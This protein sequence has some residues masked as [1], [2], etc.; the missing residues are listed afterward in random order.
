[1]NK[2]A[3]CM[4]QKNYDQNLVMILN[5][6]T[7]NNYLKSHRFIFS[8]IFSEGF[9]FKLEQ[10]NIRHLLKQRGTKQTILLSHDK[11]NLGC[12]LCQSQ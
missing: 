8:D 3:S 11:V 12:V 7:L 10:W 4:I 2:T 6:F 5:H 9:Q 1:M